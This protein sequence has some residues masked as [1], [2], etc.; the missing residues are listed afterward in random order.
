VQVGGVARKSCAR[1]IS[2]HAPCR[3]DALGKLYFT[4]SAG[5]KKTREA[6]V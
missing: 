2:R 3:A 5:R 6:V 4:V 1:V